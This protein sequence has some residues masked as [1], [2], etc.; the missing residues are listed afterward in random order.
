[1]IQ[2][3]SARHD[4]ASAMRTGWSFVAFGFVALA[5][6]YAARALLGLLM[7]VRGAELGWSKSLVSSDGALALS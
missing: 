2:G 7:P 6:A 1:M 3:H 4:H 5:L